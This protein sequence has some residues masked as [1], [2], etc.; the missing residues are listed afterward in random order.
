VPLPQRPWCDDERVN[1]LSRPSTPTAGLGF[2][3]DYAAAVERFAVA[4]GWADLRSSV[5]ACPGWSVYDLVVHL[6]NIHAWAATIVETGESAAESNDEPRSTKPR[7]VSEWYFA[8]AEDLYQVLRQTPP[9]KPCWNFVFGAGDAE[10]WQRRQLHETTMHQVDLDVAAGRSTDI[11]PAI[12][13]DG[14]DE[15]LTVMLPRM[16][17]K[18]YPVA[19]SA[20]LQL[21]ASDTGDR[22]VLTTPAGAEA[23]PPQVSRPVTAVEDVEDRVVAPA[24]V[25]YRAL[26]HRRTEPAALRIS[27]VESR[28]RAFLDSRLTS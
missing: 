26:W 8:K 24:G 13:A 6:G 27:G 19:L 4:V 3:E 25:L 28:V 12:A 23:G 22:W 20:P 21:T 15:L 14:I 18:G 7:S 10:F 16:S 1:A 17:H 5:A 9:Q 2:V 11:S